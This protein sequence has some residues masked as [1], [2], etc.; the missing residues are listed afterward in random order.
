MAAGVRQTALGMAAVAGGQQ[1][2]RKAAAAGLQRGQGLA[3]AGQQLLTVAAQQFGFKLG[4]EIGQAGHG[5]T[6]Q[7]MA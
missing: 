2:R 6:L 4:D 3:V 7:P 5:W 1:L